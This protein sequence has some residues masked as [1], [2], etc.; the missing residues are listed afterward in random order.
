[1]HFHDHTHILSVPVGANITHTVCDPHS[2]G[3]LS[4]KIPVCCSTGNCSL[5]PCLSPSELKRTRIHLTVH[6]QQYSDRH[7]HISPECELFLA[8]DVSWFEIR[9]LSWSFDF[10]V[11]VCCSGCLNTCKFLLEFFEFLSSGSRQ[12]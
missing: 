9:Y 4:P 12:S 2:G 10:K 11:K 6:K 1:M 7:S 3:A 8:A 5:F